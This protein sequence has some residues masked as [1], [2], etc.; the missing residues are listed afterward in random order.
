[1][2]IFSN[3]TNEGLEA[4]QDRVGGFAAFPTDAYDSTIKLAYAGQSDGGAHNVT[5]V[6]DMPDGREYRETIYITNKKGENFFLNKDDKTKKVPLPGFTVIND[7][8]LAT[9]E[10][11]LS[12]QQT[13][14]KVVNIYD[15]EQKK[16]LP[17]SV[18]AL[19]ALHGKP[20]TLGIVEQLENKSAKDGAGNYQPVA[21]T[22]IVNFIDKVF[23]T[24]TR[25][26]MV[27]AL[28]GQDAAFYDKWVERN[29]GQ[30]RDKRT[31]K[32]GS[33]GTAGRPSAGPPTGG[34]AAKPKSLF[35]G[36]SS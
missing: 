24:G 7:I 25:K 13:E 5:I 30:Q 23:H 33:T 26:S 2:G 34:T 11:P 1:M 31:I 35:G 18:Q 12:E 8:C 17:K 22:R 3:L 36:A 15:Y 29:Q 6:A 32:E 28:N 10:A 27:E 16:D 9:T 14:E 19:T 4:A 21:D 20:V